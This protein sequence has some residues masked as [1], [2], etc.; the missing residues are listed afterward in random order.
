MGGVALV[1]IKSAHL[2]ACPEASAL[3]AAFRRDTPILKLRVE[4]DWEPQR[5]LKALRALEAGLMELCP[6]LRKHQCRG[7]EEY[8]ILRSG[9]GRDRTDAERETTIEPQLALAHLF[10]H[11]VIDA[12]SFI[13]GEP[14]ISGATGA[15]KGSRNRFDVFVESPDA[16]V[17]RLTVGL[18]R[19]WIRDVSARGTSDGKGS[20]TFELA[21]YLYRRHPHPVDAVEAARVVGA[22]LDDVRECLDWLERSR[23]ASRILYTMNFSGFPRYGVADDGSK[24]SD[25]DPL[26]WHIETS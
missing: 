1:R 10:E 7:Q 12:V 15:L 20:L 17:A 3:N 11:V 5:P 4:I 2:R 21:R 24:P 22:E 25:S 9:N 16:I 23:A 13:T 18:A 8:H 19:G 26:S 14:L 6:S